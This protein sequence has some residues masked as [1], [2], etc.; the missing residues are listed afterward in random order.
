MLTEVNLR[1]VALGIIIFSFLFFAGLYPDCLTIYACLLKSEKNAV[2]CYVTLRYALLCYVRERARSI[3]NTVS[4]HC[5]T[6]HST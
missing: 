4:L 5:H 6:H 1:V 2:K 3:L